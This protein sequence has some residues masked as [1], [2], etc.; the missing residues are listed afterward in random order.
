M[1]DHD[2]AHQSDGPGALPDARA[3]GVRDDNV[4]TLTA[5]FARGDQDAFA[6]FYEATFDNALADARRLTGKDEA[7]CLDAVQDAYLRAARALPTMDS[8][9]ACRA[10]LRTAIASSA[11]D[12][13]RADAARARR[14]ASHAPST[15]APA[16]HDDLS[17]LLARF[18][19]ELDDRQWHALRLHIGLGLPLSAVGRAMSLS[20]HAVHGLVRRGLATLSGSV[21]GGV[22][23][24]KGETND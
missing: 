3:I 14:E 1:P 13:I 2:H 22:A 5:R 11:I 23:P 21:S 15:A 19:R 20:R 16:D 10:W 9:P 18:E 24:Q 8:W 6:M 12:R 7:F 17:E 4:R